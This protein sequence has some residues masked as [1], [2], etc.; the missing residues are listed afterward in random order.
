[1][2]A[3]Q[4][5][6]LLTIERPREVRDPATGAVDIEYDRL[7]QV[8]GAR[9]PQASSEALGEGQVHHEPK[10]NYRIRYLAEIAAPRTGAKLRLVD[11]GAPV[12]IV[13][14]QEIGRREGLLLATVARGEA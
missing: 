3:G 2:R 10:V 11:E 8:W 5:D 13:D 1:M 14:V 7:E 12:D 6:R 9:I 4:L